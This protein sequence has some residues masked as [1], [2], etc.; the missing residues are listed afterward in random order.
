M[1]GKEKF[2]GDRLN[3][4]GTVLLKGAVAEEMGSI[5]FVLKAGTRGI[6]NAKTRPILAPS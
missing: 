5:W 2:A 6:V 4:V 1:P 3:S